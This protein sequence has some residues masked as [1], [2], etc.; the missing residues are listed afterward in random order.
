M[1]GSIGI[2]PMFRTLRSFFCSRTIR[3]GWLCFSCFWNGTTVPE[4]ERE[5]LWVLLL[6]FIFVFGLF[7]CIRVRQGFYGP[8]QQPITMNFC[9]IKQENGKRWGRMSHLVVCFT[10]YKLLSIALDSLLCVNGYMV[11]IYFLLL[12]WVDIDLHVADYL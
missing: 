6:Y 5:S 10:I 3:F 4:K 8:E 2:S 12:P 9:H 7:F 11:S 1:Y